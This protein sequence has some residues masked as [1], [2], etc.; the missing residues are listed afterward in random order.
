MY[1]IS[2]LVLLLLAGCSSSEPVSHSYLLPVSD[3][4]VS[5]TLVNK[6]Q[7]VVIVRP[8]EVAEYLSGI[9]L[10]YQVSDTQV[11][12][13]QQ[14][15]WAESLTDQLTR[16]ITQ[17]LRQKQSRYWFDELTPAVSSAGMPALQ[18]RF[19]QFNGHYSGFAMLSGQW[20][21]INKSDEVV[22]R[23]PFSMQVPLAEDGYDAQV[24]ALSEGVSRL[25][26]QVSQRVGAITL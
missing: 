16:A 18:I 4:S 13:A 1:K 23:Q 10:V 5:T 22:T 17:D 15:L 9:G 21:L 20:M 8:V 2:I 25:T 24:K 26:T 3:V 6:S 11:V 12:Q 14:N 7:P 19:T